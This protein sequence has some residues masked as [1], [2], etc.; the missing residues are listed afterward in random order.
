MSVKIRFPFIG[1]C[2]RSCSLQPINPYFICGLFFNLPIILC[3]YNGSKCVCAARQG[4]TRK[5]LFLF[6]I[7]LKIFT[8]F[9]LLRNLQQLANEAV[10]FNFQNRCQATLIFSRPGSWSFFSLRTSFLFSEIGIRAATAAWV[11][12]CCSRSRV[13]RKTVSFMS[14]THLSR[15]FRRSTRRSAAHSFDS[16]PSSRFSAQHW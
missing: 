2:N 13:T 3:S 4:K 10:Y 14:F 9:F 16:Y 5:N 6:L 1:W 12:V 7:V 15:L 11:I 8:D